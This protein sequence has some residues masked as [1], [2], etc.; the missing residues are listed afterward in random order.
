MPLVERVD[1]E[2]NRIEYCSP[3]NPGVAG[4]DG[5]G[6]GHRVL[7]PKNIPSAIEGRGEQVL[8]TDEIDLIR[9]QL[10][11]ICRDMED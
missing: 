5:E 11:L 1:R 3:R 7:N 2:S 6:A 4:L 9:R 10:D 8:S